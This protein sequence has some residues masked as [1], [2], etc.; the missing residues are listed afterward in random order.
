MEK[1][2]LFYVSF[3]EKKNSSCFFRFLWDLDFRIFS[4]SEIEHYQVPLSK[5][6]QSRIHTLLTVFHAPPRKHQFYGG[7]T[8]KFQR[9]GHHQEIKLNQHWAF[10]SMMVTKVSNSTHEESVKQTSSFWK[11]FAYLHKLFRRQLCIFL[12]AAWFFEVTKVRLTLLNQNFL[13]FQQNFR[14]MAWGIYMLPQFC[15]K[16]IILWS[17]LLKKFDLST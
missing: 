16:R 10:L 8:C 2:E 3:E 12:Q 1:K 6:T 4:G 7:R 13:S 9:D 15:S 14:W 11:G 17:S 5:K